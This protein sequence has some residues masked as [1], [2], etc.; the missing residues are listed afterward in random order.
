MYVLVTFPGNVRMWS[1][2]ESTCTAIIQR[3]KLLGDL[4]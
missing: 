2:M 4:S 3:R 1:L